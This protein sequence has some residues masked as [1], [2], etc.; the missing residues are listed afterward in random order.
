MTTSKLQLPES[1]KVA[2]YL[3]HACG[4]IFEEENPFRLSEKPVSIATYVGTL[5]LAVVIF[6]NRAI[7]QEAEQHY[8]HK[9]LDRLVATARNPSDYRGLAE[10]FHYQNQVYRA[11]ADTE[12]HEYVKYFSFYHP[13]FSS[14][15]ENAARLQEH[16]SSKA[17]AAGRLAAYYDDL[18]VK[19]GFER[20]SEPLTV[21][22]E[23]RLPRRARSSVNSRHRIPRVFSRLKPD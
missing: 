2:L 16:Y 15:A 22:A 8:S 21:S 17:E 1:T 14:G 4:L 13:K 20:V 19:N 23:M 12:M 3:L 10:Y 18:L 11:K 7:G 5:T 9:E 6:G